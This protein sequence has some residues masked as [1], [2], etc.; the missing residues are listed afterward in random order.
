[1]S[2]HR[3]TREA[4]AHADVD[5]TAFAPCL[6]GVVAGMFVAT[7]F[8]VPLVQQGLAL[9]EHERGER[10][11]WRSTAM[12]APAR[13]ASALT[14]RTRQGSGPIGQLAD[15]NAKLR[16]SFDAVESEIE[17]RSWLRRASVGFVQDALLRLGAGSADVI[18]GRDGWLYYQPALRYVTDAGF[19]RA[20]YLR[21]CRAEETRHADPQPAILKF[22]RDLEA[23]D[24]ALV[25]VPVPTKATLHPEPLADGLRG[26]YP[27]LHNPSYLP[28]LEAL[29]EAGVHVLDPTAALAEMV[30][31][32]DRAYLRTDTHWTPQAMERVARALARFLE[33]RIE[34]SQPL[35][36]RWLQG[37]ATVSCRGDLSRKLEGEL[38]RSRYADEQV[39]VR[40]VQAGL[41]A[42]WRPDRA[43][44]VL[45]MGDSYTNIYAQAGM[46]WGHTAGLAEQLSFHLA[47]PVDRISRNDDSAVATRR[48]LAAELSRGR[49]RL[50]GKKV[51]VWQFGAR[52]LLHGNWEPL[53][54]PIHEA[55]G[56]QSN[57][58]FWVAPE[59]RELEIEATVLDISALPVSESAMYSDHVITIHLVD[60]Q[61]A[62]VPDR[63]TQAL[64]HALSMKDFEPTDAMSWRAGDRL[65]L[66]IRPWSDVA[67]EYESLA[68]SELENEDLEFI[69]RNWAV[70]AS[71]VD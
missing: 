62:Q 56:S 35:E 70:S 31:A 67:D 20:S 12:A 23:R 55:T 52:E 1:M 8:A 19:L 38:A 57:T 36:G 50:A 49:D 60:L 6:A 22:A 69:D 10:A 48:L 45:L 28:L 3:P 11:D 64:V 30:D 41:N 27:G 15:R 25:L 47:R 65:R 9:R 4:A 14:A 32:G 51:V 54:L 40:P 24:I 61:G 21:R 7:L 13:I 44:E 18:V 39:V 2:V 16:A 42:Y 33:S 5:A 17:E 66:R 34:L 59:K 46:G 68:S 71:R 63:C 29:Q 37:E 58:T 53:A 43:A 26:G